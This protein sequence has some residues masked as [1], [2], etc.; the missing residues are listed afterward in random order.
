MMASNGRVVIDTNVCLDLFIYR[1]PASLPL[2]HAL[3]TG[4]VVGITRTDCRDEWL[5]VL[6]YPQIETD[7]AQYRAACAAYDTC[8]R[9][10]SPSAAASAMAAA[11]LPRCSDPDD[12]KFLELALESGAGALV[13]KDKALLKLNRKTRKLGL[14]AILTPFDWCEIQV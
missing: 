2:M 3:Q 14:F 4:D 1:D 12:Q 13:T 5:R 10:L 8:L 7:E 9:P 6:R 11:S